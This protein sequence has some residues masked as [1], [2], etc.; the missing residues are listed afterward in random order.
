M[1]VYTQIS[2]PVIC[3]KCLPY[4]IT[5]QW[6]LTDFKLVYFLPNGTVSLPSLVPVPHT[7]SS[8]PSF[9]F[10]AGLCRSLKV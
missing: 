2:D 9:L 8:G 5:V 4:F 6:S 7:Q 1:G 3:N 10:A